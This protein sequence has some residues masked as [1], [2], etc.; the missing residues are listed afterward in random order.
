M[1]TDGRQSDCIVRTRLESLFIAIFV[2]LHGVWFLLMGL[3]YVCR[4]AE[5]ADYLVSVIG[6]TA[7]A[8]GILMLL[9]LGRIEFTDSFVH[10]SS[11]LH[12]GQIDWKQVKYIMVS[13]RNRDCDLDCMLQSSDT[14]AFCGEGSRLVIAGPSEWKPENKRKAVKVIIDSV[15]SH[16]ICVRRSMLVSAMISK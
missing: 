4:S 1:K 9:R 10:F 5:A 8:L 6:V 15:E 3:W 16:G 2:F 13:C 14:I 11:I 12:K 7:I